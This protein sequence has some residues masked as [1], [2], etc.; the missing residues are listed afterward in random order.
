MNTAS[1]QAV[2]CL[3]E[4]GID[5]RLRFLTRVHVYRRLTKRYEQPEISFNSCMICSSNFWCE[6][7][8]YSIAA[9]TIPG[10]LA[11]NAGKFSRSHSNTTIGPKGFGS[12]NKFSI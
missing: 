1:G 4:A 12:T 5:S 7:H 3:V 9:K 10:V 11:E 8:Q 6:R 2:P